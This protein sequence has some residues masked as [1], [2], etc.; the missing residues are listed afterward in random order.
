MVKCKSRATGSYGQIKM[1]CKWQ[2]WANLNIGQMVIM[3]VNVGQKLIMEKSKCWAN[4]NY[5]Q[6]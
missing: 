6:M 4:G 5:G 2:L 3:D 1:S